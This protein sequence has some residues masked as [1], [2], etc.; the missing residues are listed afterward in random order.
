MTICY[1]YLYRY[2][3]LFVLGP[4]IIGGSEEIFDIP[5]LRQMEHYYQ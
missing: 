5:L 3:I 1:I 2:L 4:S